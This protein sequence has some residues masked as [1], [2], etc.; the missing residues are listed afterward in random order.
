M[1]AAL[2]N[3]SL[4]TSLGANRGESVG[5]STPPTRLI[6]PGVSSLSLMFTCGATVT[7]LGSTTSFLGGGA[8]GRVGTWAIVSSLG[9]AGSKMGVNKVLPPTSSTRNLLPPL[10]ITLLDISVPTPRR[11]NQQ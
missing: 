7:S 10:V 5:I 3:S 2:I 8:L 9:A 6:L 1:G 11:L 4:S